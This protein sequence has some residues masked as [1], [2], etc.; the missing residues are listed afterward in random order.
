MK[1]RIYTMILLVIATLVNAQT[2]TEMN[3]A[4]AKYEKL[5]VGDYVK[6]YMQVRNF[7]DF[8]CAGNFDDNRKFN[9]ETDFIL[10]GK[11]TEKFMIDG[12][13][14]YV[15]IKIKK[16]TWRNKGVKKMVVLLEEMKI[17]TIATFNLWN[18]EIE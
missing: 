3:L 5:K 10:S 9:P 4:K 12:P 11:V 17:G 13:N 16:M 15:K 14:W 1:N 2:K 6:V 18:M 8:E 7:G